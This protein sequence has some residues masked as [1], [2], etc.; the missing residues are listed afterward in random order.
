MSTHGQGVQ[1]VSAYLAKRENLLYRLYFY[2]INII[3]VKI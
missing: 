2:L 1:K 3:K